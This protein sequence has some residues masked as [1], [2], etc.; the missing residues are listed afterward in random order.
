MLAVVAAAGGGGGGKVQ[1]VARKKRGWSPVTQLRKQANTEALRFLMLRH[2]CSRN[3]AVHPNLA[4]PRPCV[5]PRQ[6]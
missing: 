4:P 1:P 2:N 3:L 5:A 6:E